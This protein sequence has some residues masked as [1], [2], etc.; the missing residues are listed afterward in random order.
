M[1]IYFML[2]YFSLKNVK[3]FRQRTDC[4]ALFAHTVSFSF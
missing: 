2:K 3:G 4:F 1:L